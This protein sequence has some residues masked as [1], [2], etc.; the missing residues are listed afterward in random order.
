[1]RKGIPKSFSS[2]YWD[3]IIRKSCG[4]K[5]EDLWRAHLKEVYQRLM[6]RWVKNSRGG[7][8]LKTDLYDEAVSI[9]NLIPL[10]EQKCEHII[11]TD[12]SFGVA[13]AAK[14]RMIKEWNGWHNVVCSD[15]VNLAF[16]SDSFDQ[17]ISNSTLDHFLNKKDIIV[18]LKELWRIMKPGGTLIITLDNPSNP[19]VFLRNLSPYR[20]LKL[21][22]IIPFYMG[23]TLSKSELIRI[24]ESSGFRVHDSTAIVHS[25]RIIAIWTGYILAKIGSEKAMIYF[26]KLLRIFER[27]EKFPTRYLTG[28]FVAVKA[29]KR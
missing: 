15:I 20:L 7:L 23:V 1:M 21:F 3:M 16:K 2:D 5:R 19:V 28:Y 8:A 22:G 24:L 6:D 25:P 17:I 29:I 14:R 10:C 11:G 9:Y 4:S 27:L 12:V 26:Y 13:M 18:S